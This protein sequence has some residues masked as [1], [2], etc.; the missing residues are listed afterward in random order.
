MGNR[1]SYNGLYQKLGQRAETAGIPD[2]HPH[3]LRHTAASRWLRAGG[4][5]GGLMQVAGW[6]SRSM[7]DRYVEDTAAERAFEEAKRL[8]LGEV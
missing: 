4:S 2:F 5:E 7:L 6:R 1:L 8:N 3:R